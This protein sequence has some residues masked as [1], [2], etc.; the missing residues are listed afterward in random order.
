MKYI[1][2]LK[3]ENIEELRDILGLIFSQDGEQYLHDIKQESGRKQK[4]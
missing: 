2:T 3:A 1:V 4:A